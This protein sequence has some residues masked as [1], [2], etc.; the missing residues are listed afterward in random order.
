MS[1]KQGSGADFKELRRK[2]APRVTRTPNIEEIS[3]MTLTDI[4][5]LVHELQVHQAE[6]EVQNEE[7]RRAQI[8]LA[9]SR[10][11][12][13]ELYDFSPVGYFTLDR[14]GIILGVNLSGAVMVNVERSRLV[15]RPFMTLVTFHDHGVFSAT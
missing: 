9:K 13:V 14:S 4:T 11:K 8:E 12:Y 7:L 5:A 2:A 10:D 6:L 15:G 1:K 3:K